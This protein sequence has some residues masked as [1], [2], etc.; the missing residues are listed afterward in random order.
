[1]CDVDCGL[2]VCVFA[3]CAVWCGVRLVCV[4]C[5]ET[6]CGWLMQHFPW[7]G[8]DATALDRVGCRRGRCIV[9]PRRAS[10]AS[11]RGTG[12]RPRNRSAMAA[13]GMSR[14]KALYQEALAQLTV[15]FDRHRW[16]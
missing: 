12:K 7:L 9:A 15:R 6:V 3:A 5:V 13:A 8:F 16:R 2:S 10:G 14:G 1:M 11:L 4:V